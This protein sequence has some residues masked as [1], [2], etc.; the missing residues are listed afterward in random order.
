MVDVARRDARRRAGGRAPRRTDNIAAEMRH[1]DAAATEA[2]FA[3]AAHRVALDLVNQR[4][5]PVPIEPR[6]I[7]ASFD[8]ATGRIDGA[9]QQ[10]DADRRCATTLCRRAARHR[11]ATRCASLVGDV[12]GGFGMKT[13]LYPE[14]VV[15]ASRRAR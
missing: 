8:A 4:V 2:A 3:R 10:P 5:A 12:G 13:G 11:A 1:G 7:V 9:H 14:D 6:A 15:V